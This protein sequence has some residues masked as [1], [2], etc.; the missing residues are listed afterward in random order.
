MNLRESV[1]LNKCLGVADAF[2]KN[3]QNLDSDHNDNIGTLSHHQSSVLTVK[4]R[5]NFKKSKG[6]RIDALKKSSFN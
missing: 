2:L 1:L 4:M 6:S 3:G 5:T